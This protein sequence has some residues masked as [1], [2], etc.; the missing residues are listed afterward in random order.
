MARAE[1]RESVT[2]KLE[3]Q[4]T[5]HQTDGNE[6]PED[7][8]C[9]KDLRSHDDVTLLELLNPVSRECAAGL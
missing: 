2:L 9:S 8:G 4:G 7:G 3:Q 5:T 1:S 6:H